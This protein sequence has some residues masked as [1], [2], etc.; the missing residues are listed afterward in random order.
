[1]SLNSDYKVGVHLQHLHVNNLFQ[2]Y[3]DYNTVLNDTHTSQYVN[4]KFLNIYFIKISI[5]WCQALFNIIN[6][7]VDN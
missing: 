4:N 1:M 6:A 2:H 3:Y 7:H 5:I